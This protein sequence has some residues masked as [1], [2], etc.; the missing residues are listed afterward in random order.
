MRSILQREKFKF[1]QKVCCVQ[2]LSFDLDSSYRG[3]HKR[4]YV[5][6]KMQNAVSSVEE[7]FMIINMLSSLNFLGMSQCISYVIVA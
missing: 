4:H 2:Q 7:M 6:F 1:K 3:G 5:Y